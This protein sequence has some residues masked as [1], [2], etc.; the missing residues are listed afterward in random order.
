MNRRAL[1]GG[2]GG[3]AAVVLVGGI[4]GIRALVGAASKASANNSA[5][6]YDPN[7][8]PTAAGA[9]GGITTADVS[10]LI[11][12][13]NTALSKRDKAAFLARH[14]SGATATQAGRMFDNLG[15][16]TF[17][18]LEYQVIGEGGRVFNSGNGS[19]VNVDIALVHQVTGVDATE[20]PEWYRWTVSRPTSS[21]PIV[22]TAVAGSP[23]I[24]GQG[25]YVYYP[26][27][28][29]SPN[30]IV[31]VERPNLVLAA[32]TASDGKILS[33]NAD[34]FAEAI[35]NNR[36]GWSQAGGQTKGLA[37]GAFIV[38][39]STRDK[40]YYWY[41]GK[42]NQYGFEAGITIPVL[43][44]AS[45]DNM[46]SGA[47][48]VYGS[49]IVLDLTTSYFTDDS[50]EDVPQ[51]LV[52][53]EDAHNIM[54]SV[55]TTD[56][57]SMPLWIVEGFA[58]FMATR[59]YSNPVQNYLQLATLKRSVSSGG[60]S[61]DGHTFPS[62]AQVY[63]IDPVD[64]GAGYA[65]STLAYYYIEQKY[66][67]NK[68]IAFAQGNYRANSTV[69]GTTGMDNPADIASSVLGV[70]LDELQTDWAAFVHQTIGR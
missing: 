14:A 53:H 32:E 48:K 1:I 18:K 28:W 7:T 6:D 50:G 15:K 29:D 43:N 35:K 21:A 2:I 63:A 27:I 8:L 19:T 58:D 3:G 20:L 13:L 64:M 10:A 56:Q 55:M 61:W 54:F 65:L 41:S 60:G 33:K 59:T 70:S 22:I 34:V 67:M 47:P 69:D 68:V 62:N 46:G 24:L 51:T 36:T 5:N 39:T 45:M 25:K 4:F 12:D 26:A 49:R 17:D 9:S 40:F 23:I 44:A 42:A 66:G 57:A 30:D 31:V 38:G 11:K 52:Q 37:P 16:F